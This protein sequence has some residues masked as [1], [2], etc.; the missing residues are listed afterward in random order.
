MC[1][2]LE[3]YFPDETETF[4]YALAT[5]AV[6]NLLKKHTIQILAPRPLIVIKA[7]NCEFTTDDGEGLRE[8]YQNKS[9][10]AAKQCLSEHNFA[11]QR[12]NYCRLS[13]SWMEQP[14]MG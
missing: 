7:E 1:R 13:A 10:C 5:N 3:A 12:R 6:L 4:A 14:Q 8:N 2:R 9:S 11:A